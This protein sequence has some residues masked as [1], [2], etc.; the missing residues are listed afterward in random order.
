MGAQQQDLSRNAGTYGQMM[1]LNQQ[2]FDTAQGRMMQGLGLSPSVYGLGYAPGREL[3]GIGGQMQ[4]QQQSYLDSMYGQFQ[5]AQQWPFKTFDAMM[6]P[7]GRASGGQTT[8]TGPQANPASQMI[9]GAMFG[10]QLYRQY[11]NQNLPPG[12][13]APQSST[14]YGMPQGYEMP[15][16]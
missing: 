8:T 10:N 6:A 13:T 15:L 3:M 16:G 12:Y 9:G 14:G 5:D 4:G 11:Q 2:G 1:G 7:F